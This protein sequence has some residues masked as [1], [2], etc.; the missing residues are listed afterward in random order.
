MHVQ[1]NFGCLC[2]KVMLECGVF[3][4]LPLKVSTS[5]GMSAAAQHQLLSKLWGIAGM[6][7]IQKACLCELSRK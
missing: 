1:L 3:C 2:E 7:S 6:C 4:L 5:R